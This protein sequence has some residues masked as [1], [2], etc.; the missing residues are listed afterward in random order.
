MRPF[1]ALLA[2]A[3]LAAGCAAT[4]STVQETAAPAAVPAVTPAP[5]P[6]SELVARVDTIE[7]AGLTEVTA[8]STLAEGEV[9]FSVQIGAFKEPANASAAQTRARE[10]YPFPVLN[11]FQEHAGLY[12]IRIGSFATR[13]EAQAHLQRMKTDFP[14]DYKHSFILQLTR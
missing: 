5:P 10:R 3:L 11:E 9:R 1:I 4:D 2:G 12:R 7:A 14:A 6:P 13:E 8:D